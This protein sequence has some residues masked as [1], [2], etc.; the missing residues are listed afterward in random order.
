MI[1]NWTVFSVAFEMSNSVWLYWEP[2]GNMEML[3][4]RVLK[5]LFQCMLNI[6]SIYITARLPSNFVELS[7]A[8]ITLFIFYNDSG[9]FYE[10][11][12]PAIKQLR[13]I[14]QLY[15]IKTLK[16]QYLRFEIL[17][18]ILLLKLFF[19]WQNQYNSHVC[20]LNVKPGECQLDI[21]IGSRKR[22]KRLAYP[23]VKSI[24]ISLILVN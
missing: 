12:H 7:H 15:T 10:N 11:V 18:S 24:L 5:I 3:T 8:P 21:K 20:P 13:Y 19:R 22:E 9:H 6:Y 17:G 4:P 1:L 23:E 16:I 2:M 14:V